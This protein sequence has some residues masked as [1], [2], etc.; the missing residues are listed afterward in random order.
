[1]VLDSV[2]SLIISNNANFAVN[3][4]K[5]GDAYPLKFIPIGTSVCSFEF[6]PGKGAQIA[7]SAGNCGKVIRKEENRVIVQVD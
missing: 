7:R 5:D 6:Y 4:V 1:V 2:G 3:I